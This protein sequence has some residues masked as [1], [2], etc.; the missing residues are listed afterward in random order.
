MV[1]TMEM[2]M[3]ESWIKLLKVLVWLGEGQGGGRVSGEFD[4]K[5]SNENGTRNWSVDESLKKKRLIS[6][7]WVGGSTKYGLC[8]V[9]GLGVTFWSWVDLVSW[10]KW[11]GSQKDWRSV[12]GF[13]CINLLDG[14]QRLSPTKSIRLLLTLLFPCVAITWAL[15]FNFD[16]L[17]LG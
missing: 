10:F 9:G 4:A 11:N 1:S 17:E 14:I 12:R 7:G 6:F 3:R 2:W 13:H 15:E 5:L 8:W 16:G